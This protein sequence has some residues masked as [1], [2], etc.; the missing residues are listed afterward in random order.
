M[1]GMKEGVAMPEDLQA[2]C[3]DVFGTVVD[4]RTSVARELEALLAPRGVRRDWDAMARAWRRRYQP[5]MEEVR[6]G[7]RPFAKLDILHRENLEGMLEEFGVGG[8]SGEDL[9]HLN[10]AWHRLD[11]W[12]DVVE[13]LGRLRRRYI[14]ATLS[15]G[16]VRLMVDMA[17]RAGLPWDAIL[18][19]EPARAYK[20]RPEAYLNSIAFLD[21]APSAT[22]MVAAH[23]DDLVAARSVGMRTAF[24]PRPLEYGAD[25]AKDLEPA[26]DWDVVARDFGDL[27][28]KLGCRGAHPPV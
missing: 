16:N 22:M 6:A 5:A 23:N 3:F 13:G 18:G 11:P 20:F 15:N 27:A 19:A 9:T 25:Q 14:L 26:S 1:N 17:K 4:W 12:P 24:V 21:L 8:L 7:R 2:L 28:S 10:L